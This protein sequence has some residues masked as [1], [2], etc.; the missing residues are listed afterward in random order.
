MKKLS[1]HFSEALRTIGLLSLLIVV[2]VLATGCSKKQNNSATPTSK[3]LVRIWRTGQSEDVLKNKMQ[4]FTEKNKAQNVSVTYSERNLASYELDSL[5]SLSSRLG[6]DIWSIP[7]D[8]IGDHT[9]R[10]NPLPDNFY[11]PRN[12][13]GER[14]AT[15]PSPVDQVKS[16]YPAGIAEQIIS[17]DG[18]SVEAL[19]VSVDS[20]RLYVNTDLLSSA[21]QAFRAQAG[22]SAKSEDL[23]PIQQLLSKPPV[24]WLDLVEQAKYVTKRDGNTIQQA[25]IALGTADNIPNSADI[26][27]MLMMQNGAQIVSTDRRNALF[28][29][30]TKTSSGVTVI[31]GELALDFFTSFSNPNKPNYTW[32]PSMPQAVDAFGQGKVAMIIGFIDLDTMLKEKYPKMHYTIAPIPQKSVTET[33]VNLIR[34]NVEGVTKTADNAAAAFAFLATYTDVDTSTDVAQEMK[35]LT[36]YKSRLEARIDD[37]FIKQIL[38]GKAVYKRSHTQFDEAFRQMIVEVS[39]NGLAL[40]KA[41]DAGAETINQLLQEDTLL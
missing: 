40:G 3:V 8:W 10:L 11:F 21:Y 23:T 14:A 32:N 24:T 7:N 15:G 33:A 28:H 35:L 38:T 18:K 39:Q 5:K 29:I 25:T 9:P 12:S 31:P 20:L 6:P 41:V 4:Q 2:G 27:Q 1:P 22:S 19:P 26:L 17:T 34:F 30:P 36:P 37:P 16:L 13:K